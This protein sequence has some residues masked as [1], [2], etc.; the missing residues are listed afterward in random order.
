[1][2][3]SEEY[4]E[5]LDRKIGEYIQHK[6][7]EQYLEVLYCIFEGIE[8]NYALSCPVEA[9]M[10]NLTCS[11]LFAR[12]GHGKQRLVILTQKD[13]AD[14]S[15]VAGLKLQGL[16]YSIIRLEYCDGFIFNPNG[17]H[18]FFAPKDLF[19]SSLSAAFQMEKDFKREKR[20]L[21]SHRISFDDSNISSLVYQRPINYDDFESIENHIR[22]MKEDPDDF[23]TLDLKEDKDDLQFIQTRRHG[24]SWYVELGFDMSDFD[25][26]HSLIM[27]AEI[28]QE[29][30]VELFK[31][32]LVH[33]VS[34]DDLR[35]VQ[36][37]F[38]DTGC[39]GSES[40]SKEG[41][42]VC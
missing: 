40:R 2:D 42:V 28:E 27:G 30:A 41:S 24:M 16:L 10:E 17:S 34:P 4:T 13:G 12:K 36:E 18:R 32:I 33:G 37:K 26:D 11:P 38:R 31:M 39:P 20:Q 3:V 14:Y 29:E 6:G 5:R 7:P 15:V 1:M 21:C 23:V 9:D 25:W 35:I 22:N 19:L 8:K